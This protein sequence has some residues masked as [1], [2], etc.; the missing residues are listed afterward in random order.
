MQ[1]S[2]KLCTMGTEVHIFNPYIKY[3]FITPLYEGLDDFLTV[4]E[5]WPYPEIA[6]TALVLE[7]KSNLQQYSNSVSPTNTG[8]YF[9]VISPLSASFLQ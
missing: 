3:L 1:P 2:R 6:A 5:V 9:V 8:R 4:S 7:K